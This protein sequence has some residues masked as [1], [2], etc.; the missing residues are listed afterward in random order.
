MLCMLDSLGIYARYA[1]YAEFARYAEYAGYARFA[2][3]TR[4]TA[5]RDVL[6]RHVIIMRVFGY[7]GVTGLV[8]ARQA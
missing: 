6:G 1:G 7:V 4:Y 8:L 3:F 2:G 5:M